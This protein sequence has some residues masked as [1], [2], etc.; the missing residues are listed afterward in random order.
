MRKFQTN[1]DV[2]LVILTDFIGFID[3]TLYMLIISKK[4]EI[5]GLI[6][7]Y[8]KYFISLVFCASAY[9]Y[10]T[11]RFQLPEQSRN[12]F[13]WEKMSRLCTSLVI[14]LGLILSSGGTHI[15]LSSNLCVPRENC[16]EEMPFFDFSSTIECSDEEVCCEK[17]NVVGL[18]IYL[19]TYFYQPY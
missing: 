19:H 16:R 12:L 5:P 1:G 11:H 3:R 17:S 18:Y 13:D 6:S 4:K 14:I 9:R 8:S 15:C 10:E 7:I 2:F